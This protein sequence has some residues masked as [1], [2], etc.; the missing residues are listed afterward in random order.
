[1]R[2]PRDEVLISILPYYTNNDLSVI[3]KARIYHIIF[4][5]FYKK[6]EQQLLAALRRKKMEI[7]KYLSSNDILC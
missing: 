6:K 7:E 5:D 1:M 4:N 2:S 3:N